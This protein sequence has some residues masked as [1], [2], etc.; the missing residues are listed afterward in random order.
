MK[1]TR[2]SHTDISTVT[3]FFLVMLLLLLWMIKIFDSSEVTMVILKVLSTIILLGTVTFLNIL[4]REIF[5][6]KS[7]KQTHILLY[8]FLVTIVN[9]TIAAI[10]GKQ[11]FTEFSFTFIMFALHFFLSLACVLINIRFTGYE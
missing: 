6:K 5:E 3:M 7:K 10:A 1:V 2:I 9:V 8:Y 4:L 11:N